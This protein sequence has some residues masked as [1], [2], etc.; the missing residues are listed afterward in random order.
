MGRNLERLVPPSLVC[1]TAPTQ[2]RAET[3]ALQLVNARTEPQEIAS[4]TIFERRAREKTLPCRGMTLLRYFACL[5]G[6]AAWEGR[7][8]WVGQSGL[9]LC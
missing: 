1:D 4:A 7:F 3:F 5:M 9:E 6:K 8:L 2:P